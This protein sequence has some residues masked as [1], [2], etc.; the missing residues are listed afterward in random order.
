MDEHS[1]W[2]FT[3][4]F[5]GILLIMLIA[6]VGVIFFQLQEV[7]SFKQQVNYQIERKGGL[8]E[9]AIRELNDYAQENYLSAYQIESDKLN[10]KVSF[11]DTVDYT[12]KVEI[13]IHFYQVP[14]IEYDSKGS[15]VSQVR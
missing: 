2:E 14:S 8:T 15:G 9:E 7:N 11:G 1:I 12:I 10:E 4:W 13:P 6:S 5:I 3:K